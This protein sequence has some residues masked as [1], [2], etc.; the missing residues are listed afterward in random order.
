MK[1]AVTFAIVGL[2]SATFAGCASYPDNVTELDDARERVVEVQKTVTSNQ[3]M[4]KLIEAREALQL[5]MDLHATRGDLDQVR[6]FS[7]EAQRLADVAEERQFEADVKRAIDDAEAERSWPLDSAGGQYV[8]PSDGLNSVVG[9]T[10]PAP[11]VSR[12]ENLP[13]GAMTGQAGIDDAVAIETDNLIE[14]IGLLQ[15]ANVESETVI[16]FKDVFFESDNT[17]LKPDSAAALDGIATFLRAAPGRTLRIEGHLDSGGDSDLSLAMSDARAN[18]VREELVA[19][20]VSGDRLRAVGMGEG[21]P[22][23]SNSTPEGRQLNRRVEIV[24]SAANRPGPASL[25]GLSTE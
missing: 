23:V 24:I 16:L 19:R 8:Y 1:S 2:L 12:S 5:A 20:G 10:D 22:L 13:V 25:M 21:Y 11:A 17:N 15:S 4:E 9:I 7:V 3:A 14:R 18:R 6:R